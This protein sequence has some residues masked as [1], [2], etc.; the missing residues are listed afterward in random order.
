VPAGATLT[1]VTLRDGS[2]HAFA[3]VTPIPPA[4]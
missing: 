1:R 3:T 2:G 4:T